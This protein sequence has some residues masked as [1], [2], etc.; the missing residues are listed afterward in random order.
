MVWYVCVLVVHIRGCAGL[1]TSWCSG[2]ANGVAFM[3]DTS[4]PCKCWQLLPL[5]AVV[6]PSLDATSALLQ[7]H[8]D[9]HVCPAL[10]FFATSF[11]KITFFN[12]FIAFFLLACLFS[13]FADARLL[14]R[15]VL[16]HQWGA[17]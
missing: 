15:C 2:C 16:T 7:C 9:M 13:L 6:L 14:C 12:G 5:L 17:L 10:N 11:M 4:E 1:P 8:T 3:I